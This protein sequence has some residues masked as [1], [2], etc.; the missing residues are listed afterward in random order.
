MT[1]QHSNQ[2]END[3]APAKKM[4]MTTQETADKAVDYLNK[5]KRPM[6]HKSTFEYLKPTDVQIADMATC[7]NAASEY[8]KVL[9]NIVPDGPDKTYAIRKLREVAMWVNIAITRHPDGSPR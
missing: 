4:E 1:E 9:Q 6:L 8:T 3:V 5:D 7:R 2:N